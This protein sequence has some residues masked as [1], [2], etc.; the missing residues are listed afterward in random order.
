VQDCTVIQRAPGAVEARLDDQVVVLSALNFSRH[1]LD[2]KS[3]QFWILF[4]RRL[5]LA[6][7]FSRLVG[8]FSADEQIRRPDV[9]PFVDR[10]AEMGVVTS[11]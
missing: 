2:P 9:A 5:M 6:D 11:T 7:L 10:M 3:A 8:I 4:E 1:A